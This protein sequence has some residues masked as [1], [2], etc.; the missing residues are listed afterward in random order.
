MIGALWNGIS[1]MNAMQN[2]LTAESN[3]VA[4]INTV[5]YKADTTSFSDMAYGP[6]RVGKGAAPGVISKDFSQGNL[7]A[8]GGDYDLAI[9]GKGF[10]TAYDTQNDELR[11]TRSGDFR[12]GNDGTLQMP[13][14]FKVQGIPSGVP[15]V[16]STDPNVSR[17]TSA[18]SRT[19]ASQVVETNSQIMTINTKSTDYITSA[20][21]SG[22][23]G[24]DLK[25][26]DAKISDIE[27]LRT[28]YT[29][30]LSSYASNPTT[31]T[32]PVAQVNSVDFTNFATELVAEGDY[33]EIVIDGDVIRESFNTDAQTTMNNFADRISRVPGLDG[34]V[35]AL[36][37]LTV[38]SI[39]PG[40]EI[41]ITSPK[42]NTATYNVS[43][44]TSVVLGSG[45]ANVTALK[46]L[47]SDKIVDA[48]AQFIDL[49]NTLD[50]TTTTYTDLQTK[51]TDLGISDN[52][53]GKPEIV[54]GVIYMGQAE[55]KFVIGKV[56]VSAFTNASLLKAEGGNVYSMVKQ[57]PE[58]VEIVPV[59]M[60]GI[61]TVQSHF[62]ELSNSEL[63]GGLVN[64]MVYQRAFEAN[65]KLF[66]AADE[67]LNIAIS[68]KK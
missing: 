58:G 67:F 42:I 16:I 25:T 55:N 5:G 56:P 17:I 11:Y 39:V 4:N 43:T 1:G 49:T 12:V 13:N 34:S 19:L 14:T 26:A 27:L 41:S 57:T 31:G 15:T 68:L 66:A 33:I 21:T 46:T 37:N 59:S 10:F 40:K 53:F 50:L 30:A 52:Q 32:A 51:L 47:L 60:A 8:S 18:Y 48:G 7:K 45:M 9:S 3:N 63:S 23:S 62:L 28:S 22:T 6:G 54:D 64:L 38:A 20:T 35:D 61:S 24:T 29:T 65:S 2:A 44:T 36:G